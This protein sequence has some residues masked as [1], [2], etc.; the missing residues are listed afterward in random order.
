MNDKIMSRLQSAM[1]KCLF[2]EYASL[3][4]VEYDNLEFGFHISEDCIIFEITDPSTNK[5]YEFT[6]KKSDLH[7]TEVTD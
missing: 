4:Y 3:A 1:L 7:F 2:L 5:I 6:L